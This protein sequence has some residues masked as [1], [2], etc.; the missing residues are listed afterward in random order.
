MS[1][2]VVCQLNKFSQI[3]TQIH[4]LQYYSAITA[5]FADAAGT[6]KS[7]SIL[8]EDVDRLLSASTNPKAIET[9]NIADVDVSEKSSSSS[10][11]MVS[12]NLLIQTKQV[13]F[14]SEA[15]RS[16]RKDRWTG[17]QAQVTDLERYGPRRAHLSH[18]VDGGLFLG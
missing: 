18:R 17:L 5:K 7:L 6:Q 15:F 10:S 2:A 4:Q 13:K 8:R 3:H 16:Q 14:H 12:M 1:E 11:P 9:P